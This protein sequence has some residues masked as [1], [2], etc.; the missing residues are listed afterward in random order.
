MTCAKVDASY[1]SDIRNRG[2]SHA[3]R[4]AELG[5]MLFDRAEDVMKKLE[6]LRELLVGACD[7]S[8]IPSSDPKEIGPADTSFDKA[9]E[10]F[11]AGTKEAIRFLLKE[12]GYT[13]EQISSTVAA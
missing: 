6:N 7:G 11:D 10:R 13:V 4:R 1:V 12:G 3:E 5:D 9:V 2:L 8:L